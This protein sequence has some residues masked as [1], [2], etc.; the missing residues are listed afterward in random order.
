MKTAKSTTEEMDEILFEHRNKIYGAYILRKMYN[1]QLARAIFLAAA[2]MIAGLA[3]PLVSSYNMDYYGRHI[4]NDEGTTVILDPPPAAD[5]PVIPPLPPDME[6]RK[7]FVFAPPIVVAGDVPDVI[8]L[9]MDDFNKIS[10]NL[11]VDISVETAVE[12]RDE[13]IEI[14]QEEPALIFVQE[15]P[16][17]PGGEAERMKFLVDNIKYPPLALENGIQG[18]VYVQFI[19]DSRGN[20]TDFKIQRGIGGG[21]DEEAERVIKMMPQWHAG[22]QNGK[23]VRVIYN[24]PVVFK[25]NS[26]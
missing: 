12:K 7:Q 18:T 11:P 26:L 16:S 13:V 19:I 6:T 15:M 25:I 14:K 8:G 21:C 24:M 3:Y 23:A 5:I 2:I 17:Y 20:I 9:N 10:T 22:K 4:G 1:K